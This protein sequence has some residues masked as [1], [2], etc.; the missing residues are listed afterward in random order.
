M[1]HR[2]RRA[3]QAQ[4]ATP[5]ADTAPEAKPAR[6]AVKP[7]AKAKAKPAAKKPAKRRGR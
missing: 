6:A 1:P 2:L 5:T 3:N 7:A 4:A